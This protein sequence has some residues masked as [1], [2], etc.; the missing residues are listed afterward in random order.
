MKLAQSSSATKIKRQ[1]I[2]SWYNCHGNC[3]KHTIAVNLL[4]GTHTSLL[5]IYLCEDLTQYK[6]EM[7]LSAIWNNQI[8]K[9]TSRWRHS[10]RKFGL[11]R[12][13]SDLWF[14]WT[15]VKS[16]TWCS[17]YIYCPKE[18][19]ITVW[20]DTSA[21]LTIWNIKRSQEYSFIPMEETLPE[22]RK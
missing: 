21:Y 16:L 3:E 17:K 19:A 22:S 7:T 10:L 8:P 4:G 2:C 9:F 12:T 6:V 18:P 5:R 1:S 20:I 15:F 14:M 11:M 13:D